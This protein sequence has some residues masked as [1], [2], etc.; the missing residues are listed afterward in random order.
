MP[1][2]IGPML[3]T[4]R[5]EAG[6]T[7]TALAKRLKITPQALSRIESAARE[8]PRWST[9]ARIAAILDVSLDD[10]ASEGGYGTRRSGQR[11]SDDLRIDVALDAIDRDIDR[12]RERLSSLRRRK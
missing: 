9:V 2:P 11:P 7:Q 8:D 1:K 5:E 10:L 3:R 12:L 4:R 6:V